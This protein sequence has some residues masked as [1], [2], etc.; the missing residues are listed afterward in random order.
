MAWSA[1]EQEARLHARPA[2]QEELGETLGEANAQ[3]LAVKNVAGY[4]LT[5][6]HI[7]AIG[8]LG[9]L[10]EL[11]FKL[12]PIPPEHGVVVGRFA[13]VAGAHDFVQAVTHSPLSPLAIEL[14]GASAAHAAGL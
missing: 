8:T 11:S 1:D 10:T 2:S 3:G 9:V 5:K 12:A 4:D 6:L 14:L 13:D 7:G